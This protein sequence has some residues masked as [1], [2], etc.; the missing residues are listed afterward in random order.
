MK[1]IET[2]KILSAVAIFTFRRTSTCTFPKLDSNALYT[3]RMF[4]LFDKHQRAN[5]NLNAVYP[6]T[7]QCAKTC[8]DSVN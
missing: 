4:A 5:K 8:S 2:T 3:V 6:N 7:E 1:T